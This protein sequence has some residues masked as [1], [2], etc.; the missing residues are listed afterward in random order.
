[1]AACN[2][3]FECL[4]HSFVEESARLVVLICRDTTSATRVR[5]FAT[6]LLARM[7]DDTKTFRLRVNGTAALSKALV[8]E[9]TRRKVVFTA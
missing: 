1:M 5:T 8:T 2:R 6:D 9:L 4:L 7:T 3:Q